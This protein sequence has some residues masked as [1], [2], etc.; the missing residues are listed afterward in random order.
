MP[1]KDFPS[2][3]PKYPGY[4]ITAT[5]FD[6]VGRVSIGGAVVAESNACLVVA[7][8]DHLDQLYFPA[9]DV[10]WE[11]LAPS[12]HRSTCPFKGYASYWSANVNGEAFANV[13]WSYQDPLDEVAA[14]A[15]Y[16]AFYA[17]RV[18]VTLTEH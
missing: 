2:A 8:S 17:D 11:H 12:D 4:V 6:G 5:P 15:G 1:P 14:I 3:W 18:D 9:A 7:E 10:A 16:I 13:A